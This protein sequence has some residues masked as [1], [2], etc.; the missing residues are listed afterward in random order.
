MIFIEILWDNISRDEEGKFFLFDVCLYRSILIKPCINI[1]NVCACRIDS[2]IRVHLCVR[3]VEE[4]NNFMLLNDCINFVPDDHF[5][6]IV[7]RAGR[8]SS[9]ADLSCFDWFIYFYELILSFFSLFHI[10]VKKNSISFPLTLLSISE[11]CDNHKCLHVEYTHS[12]FHKFAF[13]R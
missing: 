12:N 3:F 10:S 2:G 1:I 6:L 8:V 13:D 4:N 7:F 11:Q 9:P 5:V